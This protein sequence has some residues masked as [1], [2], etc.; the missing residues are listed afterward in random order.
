MKGTTATSVPRVKPFELLALQWVFTTAGAQE[1]NGRGPHVIKRHVGVSDLVKTVQQ[2]LSGGPAGDSDD[3]QAYKVEAGEVKQGSQGIAAPKP[4]AIGHSIR[5]GESEVEKERRLHGRG[6]DVGPVDYLIEGVQ[7]ACVLEGVED[8]GDQ[9][10]N[11]EVGGFRG[12]PATEQDVQAD[13][14]VD[15]GDEAQ[16]V[17]D[18]FIRGLE[19]DALDFESR[20]AGGH[21]TFVERAEDGV[22]GLAENAVV[23]DAPFEPGQAGDRAV[24]DGLE[25]I[26][27]ADAGLTARGVC[28]DVLGAK[29]GGRF[30]PPDSVGWDAVGRLRCE[31]KP[32]EHTRSQ[33]DGGQHHGKNPSLECVLHSYPSTHHM[34]VADQTKKWRNIESYVAISRDLQKSVGPCEEMKI[35]ALAP[36]VVH[37][38]SRLRL[39]DV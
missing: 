38:G 2:G 32:G 39:T 27:D 37:P 17:V 7:L 34:H 3:L 36:D 29:T 14:Q 31:I 4:S 35:G 25:E 15:N 22:V 16:A 23:E 28:R 33:G 9:A 1:E 20:Y 24:I 21:V 12:G 30:H 8:E 11:E 6:D 19:D 13:E 5:E 18:G 26:A 10:E